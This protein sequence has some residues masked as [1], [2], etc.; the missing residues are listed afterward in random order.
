MSE[1]TRQEEDVMATMQTQTI[2]E[3][4]DNYA[5]LIEDEIDVNFIR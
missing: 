4:M 3:L 1:E 5:F 2:T